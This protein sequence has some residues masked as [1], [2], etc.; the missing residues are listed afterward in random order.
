MFRRFVQHNIPHQ[1]YS[2]SSPS[3]FF[4]T[5][6]RIAFSFFLSASLFQKTI[7][8]SSNKKTNK[9]IPAESDGPQKFTECQIFSFSW[10]LLSFFSKSKRRKIKFRTNFRQ[11]LINLRN[12]LEI[13]QKNQGPNS[14]T[15]FELENKFPKQK[16]RKCHRVKMT[17]VESDLLC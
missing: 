15:N 16:A 5:A 12:Y 13:G 3:D 11:E 17:W 14:S 10:W 9:R 1:S 7:S 4:A 2:I 8:S 6:S